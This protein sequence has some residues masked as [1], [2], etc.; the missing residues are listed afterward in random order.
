ML[1][2]CITYCK[3]MHFLFDKNKISGGFLSL[4]VRPV[5]CEQQIDMIWLD[6]FSAKQYVIRYVS[7]FLFGIIS[8][9]L[10]NHVDFLLIGIIRRYK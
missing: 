6:L 9:C 2:V 4:L 3:F 5:D 10:I 7:S 8:I 1:E